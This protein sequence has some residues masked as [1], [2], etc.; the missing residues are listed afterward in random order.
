MYLVRNKPKCQNVQKIFFLKFWHFG[1]SAIPDLIFTQLSGCKPGTKT[2]KGSGQD[3]ADR[4]YRKIDKD[5][6]RAQDH[7]GDTDLSEI[8][9]HGTDDADNNHLFFARQPKKQC[10]RCETEQSAAQAIGKGHHLSGYHAG[11]RDAHQQHAQGVLPAGIVQK[12]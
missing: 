6:G 10:H 12:P 7:H 3:A 11:N 5:T 4:Q 2:G 8:V 9:E 1:S